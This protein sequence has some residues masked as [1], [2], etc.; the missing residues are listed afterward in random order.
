M[1]DQGSSDGRK[2]VLCESPLAIGVQQANAMFSAARANSVWLLEAYP[3]QFQPATEA[4]C[5]ALEHGDIGEVRSVQACFG[6]T[7]CN[8]VGNIR[9]DSNLGG[10][11][12][13]DAGSYVTSLIRLVM[14][15]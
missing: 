2:H 5:A 12:L 14:V 8:P 10:G 11:S 13:L 6:F 3:Y 4:L 7:L 1:G 9:L 15:T